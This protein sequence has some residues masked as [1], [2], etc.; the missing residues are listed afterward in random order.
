MHPHIRRIHVDEDRYVAKDA[1]RALGRS[2]AELFPLQ[3]KRKLKHLFQG[4]RAPMLRGDLVERPR[5]TATHRLGPGCPRARV[6]LK[7]QH[8][9]LRIVGKPNCL[10]LAELLELRPLLG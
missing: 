3:R 8:G 10:G 4:Q 9:I 1:D 6:E 7:A 5:L 2:L